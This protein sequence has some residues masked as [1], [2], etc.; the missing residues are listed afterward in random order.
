MTSVTKNCVC[1]PVP[2]QIAITT[3]AFATGKLDLVLP[4][5]DNYLVVAVAWLTE[6]IVV[7]AVTLTLVLTPRSLT[8]PRVLAPALVAASLLATNALESKPLAYR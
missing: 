3:T 8:I 5:K 6:L 2:V 1:R 7:L 4:P